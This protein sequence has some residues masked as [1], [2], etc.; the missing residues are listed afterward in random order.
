MPKVRLPKRAQ[1]GKRGNV[2]SEMDTPWSSWKTEVAARIVI[3]NQTPPSICAHT[4]GMQTLNVLYTHKYRKT[5]YIHT[6]ILLHLSYPPHII[7]N[8]LS[9]T[10]CDSDSLLCDD[11]SCLALLSEAQSRQSQYSGLLTDA[12]PATTQSYIYIHKTEENGEIRHTF[13]YCL[14]TD[15]WKE[16]GMG[17]GE[18]TV[19]MPDPPGSYLT[20][21][22]EKVHF[23]IE[24]PGS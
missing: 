5:Y 8:L 3:S 1:G 13:C 16:L 18:E 17:H 12:R 15:Q 23:G 21:Y 14:E 24:I 20:G 9:Q 19:T 4:K 6:F 2:T 22:A 7:P 11:E 10:L